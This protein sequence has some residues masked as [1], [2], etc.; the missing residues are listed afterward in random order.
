MYS[1]YEYLAF[2]AIYAF[3]GWCAEV[4]FNTISTGH[5]VNRG[6]LKGPVCPIYGFGMVIVV[7]C[8]TPLEE[9]GALLFLGSM[10]LT[11]VLEGV[12]GYILKKVFHTSWWDYSDQPFNLGGYICLRFSILWGLGCVLVMDLI[13]PPIVRFVR[14]IPLLAGEIVIGVCLFCFACDFYVTVANILRLNRRLKRLDEVSGLMFQLSEE[15]GGGLAQ[16]ALKLAQTG[17]R[18]KESS[19]QWK[20]QAQQKR[21]EL[22]G[23]LESKGEALIQDAEQRKQALFDSLEQKKARLAQLSKEY[24]RIMQEKM[25]V[26]L[27]KAFPNAKSERYD[28]MLSRVRERIAAKKGEGKSR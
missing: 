13:H 22:R 16:S 19:A 10:V 8:L 17:E 12:T 3:L 20:E 11:S 24:E 7:L 5:F 21:E 26:R 27:L 23:R 18:V 14:W 4:V 1:F 28:E 9:N 2:F 25:P 15:I 6:F